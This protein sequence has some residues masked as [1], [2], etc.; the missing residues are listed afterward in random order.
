MEEKIISSSPQQGD[1]VNDAID[2]IY[3]SGDDGDHDETNEVENETYPP[4][5]W[6][7]MWPGIGCG[8]WGYKQAFGSDP[9]FIIPSPTNDGHVC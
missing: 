6:A 9:S 5:K 7:S 3:L 4:V 1:N 2:V 8:E